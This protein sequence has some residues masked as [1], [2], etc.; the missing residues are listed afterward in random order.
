[1]VPCRSV[2]LAATLLLLTAFVAPASGGELY[3]RV[4]GWWNGTTPGARSNVLHD[5][6]PG[7]GAAPFPLTQPGPHPWYGE[8]MGAPTYSYGYF[9]AAPHA[10]RWH[11]TGYYGDFREGGY[12]K[13]Y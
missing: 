12:S 7:P 2:R 1:M 9:G 13:G 11:H 6:Y 8:A 3:R 5:S 10:E 4:S